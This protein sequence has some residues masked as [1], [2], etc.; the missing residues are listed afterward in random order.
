MNDALDIVRMF[1]QSLVVN[2]ATSAQAFRKTSKQAK[3]CQRLVNTGLNGKRVD[4]DT[5]KVLE[6]TCVHRTVRPLLCVLGK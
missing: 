3:V 1:H 2:G 5:I 6:Q 4:K